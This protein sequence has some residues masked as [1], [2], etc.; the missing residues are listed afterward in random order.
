MLVMRVMRVMGVMR[1][2]RVMS[3]NACN[4]CSSKVCNSNMFDVC[5]V[6]ISL[7]HSLRRL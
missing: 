2:M 1:V 6:W 4:A 3:E 7:L 5:N